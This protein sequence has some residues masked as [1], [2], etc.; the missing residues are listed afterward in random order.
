M[1]AKLI[2]AIGILA[3]GFGLGTLVDV[4]NPCLP[5]PATHAGTGAHEPYARIQALA[6]EL[7]TQNPAVSVALFTVAAT[8]AM[9][10]EVRL[11]RLLRRYSQE[12]LH[13]L[14]QQRG[15]P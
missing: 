13:E 2:V 5:A 11:A 1:A 9:G 4:R 12:A 3:A 15:Q 10:D 14:E 6:E 8:M 7:T